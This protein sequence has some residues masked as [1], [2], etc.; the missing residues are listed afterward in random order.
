[1]VLSTYSLMKNAK[2]PNRIEIKGDIL[3]KM[4]KLLLEVLKDFSSVCEKYNFYYSLCGGTALGAVRHQGFIPWDDDVDVFMIRSEYDKFL[5]IFDKEL[6]DKYYLHSL[7]TTPELG[8]PVSQIIVKNTVMKSYTTPDCKESGI[9][10]DIFVLENAPDNALIRKI[11]GFGSL[12]YGFC[13]SCSRFYNNK[14]ALL[15]IFSEADNEVKDAIKKK[16]RIGSLLRF[17]SLKTWAKRFQWWNSLCKN[18]TARITDDVKPV[19]RPFKIEDW[20]INDLRTFKNDMNTM[21]LKD[22]T[23]K[24]NSTSKRIDFLKKRVNHELNERKKK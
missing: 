24:Y 16:A 5:E 15:D 18:N 10:I 13:L 1:M 3:I 8:G 2:I 22:L 23:K 9:A 19:D 14:N 7:E 21:N 6:K 20:S 12:F 11:H 17:H 4:Q